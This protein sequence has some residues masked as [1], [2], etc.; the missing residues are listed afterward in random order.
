MNKKLAIS[1]AAIILLSLYLFI[2]RSCK[3]GSVSLKPVKGEV[4]YVLIQ[5]GENKLFFEREGKNWFINEAKYP[6]D[7]FEIDNFIEKVKKLKLTDHISSQPYYERYGL[8]AQN[9]MTIILKKND[10]VLR[11]VSA[12]STAQAS[13]HMYVRI[14]DK[15]EV[16]KTDE[17]FSAES[18]M[19]VDAYRDKSICKIKQEN[20]TS[21]TFSHKGKSFTFNRVQTG[22]TPGKDDAWQSPELEGAELDRNKMSPLISSVA[23]LRASR[24]DQSGKKPTGRPTATIFIQSD[25][26]E[27][28]LT[29]FPYDMN[30]DGRAGGGNEY[31]VTSSDS[32]YNYIVEEWKIQKLFITDI[33]I[34]KTTAKD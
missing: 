18:D 28:T 11:K 4:D 29:V 21:L 31:L 7:E 23:S 13:R 34:Y 27:L 3:G 16:Y 17:T 32:K 1:A 33:S 19:N 2:A 25:K 20:I 30:K 14:D 12:G 15:P 22:I 24:F 10:N 9:E 8:D 26:D 5:K 6:A